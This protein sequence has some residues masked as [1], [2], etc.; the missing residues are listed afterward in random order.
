[1]KQFD[2]TKF[3]HDL[4]ISLESF[5]NDMLELNLLNFN[6]AF[7]LF[8]NT[9]HIVINAHAPTKQCTIRQ[10]RLQSKL[11]ISKGFYVSKQNKQK[12]YKTHYLKGLI[13]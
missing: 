5:F 3:C 1:M 13:D 9:Q 8:L 12:L 2:S 10:K 7:Q 11:W 6:D 4:Q